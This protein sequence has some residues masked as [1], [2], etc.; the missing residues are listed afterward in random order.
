VAVL[1][2]GVDLTHP[3]LVGHVTPGYNFVEND[4]QPSDA[5]NGLDDDE[6]GV[7]DEGVGHGT[8]VTCIIATVAPQARIMPI[9]VLN[10][11][12]GGTL[13]DIVNG[14]VYAVDHGAQVINLSLSSPINSPLLEAAIQYAFDHQVIVFAAAAGGAA[15]LNY[16]AAY[17][18]VIAVGSVTRDHHVTDF[19]QP[20]AQLV[21]IFAPGENIYSTYYNGYFAWWTGTSMSAPFVTG[22]A[23]LLLSP[24]TCQFA[25][26]RDAIINAVDPVSGFKEGGRVNLDKATKVLKLK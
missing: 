17:P 19:S 24:G 1:D 22:E 4:D 23:A 13:F 26:V 2:T 12:G 20:Y 7:I 5:P 8:H 16:P 3:L 10:S 9:R 15:G 18:Q 11:D 14:L 21:D 6:D 25:C